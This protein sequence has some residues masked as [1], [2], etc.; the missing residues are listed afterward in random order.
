MADKIQVIDT[1]HVIVGD[2]PGEGRR[3]LEHISEKGVNLRAFTAFPVGDGKTRLSFVTERITRLQEAA[4]DAGLEL[5]GPDR[6]FMIH[7]EDRIGALHQYHLVLANAGVNVAAS[8]C[9]IDDN[10]QFG[11]ILWVNAEDFD[12]AAWEFD[13]V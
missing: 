3:L 11:F 9:V 6:A 13:F 4:V 2:T 12:K 1:Y 7:G 5:L 10:G 8:S